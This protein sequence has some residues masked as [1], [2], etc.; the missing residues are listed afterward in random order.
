ME[1]YVCALSAAALGLDAI[2]VGGTG[3]SASQMKELKSLPGPIFI[4]RDNDEEGE[5]AA[6]RWL[7]ALYPK[8]LLCP[9]IPSIRE[10][11]ENKN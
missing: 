4:V 9:P 3:I 11:E 6:R 10:K 2:A 8:A 5:K 7:E 1:G